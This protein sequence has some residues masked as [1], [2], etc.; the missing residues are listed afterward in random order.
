MRA[1]FARSTRER[2]RVSPSGES[3]LDPARGRLAAERLHAQHFVLGSIV[4][5]GGKVQIDATLYPA[6]GRLEPTFRPS[7]SGEVTKAFDLVDE[8]AIGLLAELGAGSG[9]R[10]N[11]VAA[12]TTSSLA[13]FRAYLDGESAFQRGDF[14]SSVEQFRTAVEIDKQF[15]LAWYRLSVALE[16]LGTPQELHNQAAEQADRYADRLS[17][18]DRRLLEASK[19]WRQ[20]ANQEAK[21]LYGAIVQTYPDDIEG[22][23]QLGEVLFHRNGLYG[24]SITESRAAFERV[25]SSSRTI[26][27]PSC[28]WLESKRSKDDSTR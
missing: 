14:R 11:R 16:W 2:S 9:V 26:S 10:T 3:A 17:D 27:P 20:G 7:A 4:E 21:R 8:L 1:S 18:R 19:V 25:L 28:T 12:V 24:A 22:W 6:D 5:I 13:A 23:Y 15:A